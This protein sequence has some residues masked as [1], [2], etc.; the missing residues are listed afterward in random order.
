MSKLYLI[1]C[2]AITFLLL[3]ASGFAQYP[4]LDQEE[5]IAPLPE[6]LEVSK[7]AV[8]TI[9]DGA[10]TDTPENVGAE[11]DTQ[12]TGV[13][14]EATN[15]EP[16]AT[17]EAVSTPQTSAKKT[18]SQRRLERKYEKERRKRGS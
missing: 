17:V 16:A 13:A 14:V 10:D 8:V 4:F 15:P 7:P 11:V 12:E 1:L 6:H 9:K 18:R 2:L 5:D 3:P